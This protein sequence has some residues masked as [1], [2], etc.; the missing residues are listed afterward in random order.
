M[1]QDPDKARVQRMFSALMGMKK[2]DLAGLEQAFH[3][4]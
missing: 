3:N 2:I 4:R 1:L